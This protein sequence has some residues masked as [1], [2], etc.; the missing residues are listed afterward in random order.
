MKN[1]T[2]IAYDYKTFENLVLTIVFCINVIVFLSFTLLGINTDKYP[3]GMIKL[4]LIIT[5]VGLIFFI[6]K[7]VIRLC[8]VKRKLKE[9]QSVDLKIVRC[10]N[11]PR[12][13]YKLVLVST[14]NKQYESV[15]KVSRKNRKTISSLLKEG[16]TTKAIVVSNTEVL[17]LQFFEDFN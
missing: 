15:L 4:Y 6:I 1:R 12:D 13:Q 5:S 3:I 8:L 10:G 2:I 7:L 11:F 14:D 9:S 17:I 16:I